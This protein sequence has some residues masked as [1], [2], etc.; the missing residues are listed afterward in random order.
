MSALLI[1]FMQEEKDYHDDLS[2]ELELAD[3]DQPVLYRMGEAFFHLS[4]PAA[5]R[6]LRA[7]TKRYEADIHGLLGK[8]EECEKGMK[9]LKV[10][11]YV[12]I[13]SQVCRRSLRRSGTPNLASKSIWKPR[14]NERQV[15]LI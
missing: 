2:T 13:A 6:Q 15:G 11:L 7:D 5:K 8:A 14:R 4:L 10:L 3:D 9:E 12:L 1:G